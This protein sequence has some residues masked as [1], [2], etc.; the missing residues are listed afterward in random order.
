MAK[1]TQLEMF[2]TY[3]SITP[4][5]GI[6][7]QSVSNGAVSASVTEQ[8]RQYQNTLQQFTQSYQENPDN[9]TNH[10][11]KKHAKQKTKQITQTRTI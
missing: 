10:K 8:Q 3:K 1:T 11:S 9:I 2:P 6:Q 7:V 4:N 5:S